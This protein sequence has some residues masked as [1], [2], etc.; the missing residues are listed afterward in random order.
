MWEDDDTD[1]ENFDLN[2][3]DRWRLD[4]ELIE[5]SLLKSRSDKEELH[6]HLEST[7]DRMAR[8]GDLGMGVTE[9]RLRSELLRSP[10]GS[11]RAVSKRTGRV[12]RGDPRTC[13]V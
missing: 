1:T 13:A 11:V 3:L 10:A 8:R 7:L 6:Q 4:T 9:H 12:A 2:G 5:Q